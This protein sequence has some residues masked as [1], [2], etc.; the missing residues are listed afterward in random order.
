MAD[1]NENSDNPEN[2]SIN[3]ESSWFVESGRTPVTGNQ[4]EEDEVMVQNVPAEQK[5][6]LRCDSTERELLKNHFPA[7]A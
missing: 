7:D 4:T 3:L 1:N 2:E 5:P 6:I